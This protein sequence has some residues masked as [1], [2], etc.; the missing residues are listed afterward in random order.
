MK[1][2]G[3]APTLSAARAQRLRR[4]LAEVLLTAAF[5]GVILLVTDRRRPVFAGLAIGSALTAVHLVGIPYR[6]VGESGPLPGRCSPEES[7]QQVWLFL[8]APLVGGAIAVGDLE[9]HTAGRGCSAMR[10][11][12]RSNAKSESRRE[13]GRSPGFR[14]LCRFDRSG[15][16]GPRP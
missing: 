10:A 5:V 8:I 12:K 2:A 15:C 13:S 9:D 3:W 7:L 4:F 14:P 11:R 16:V 1:P 6:D